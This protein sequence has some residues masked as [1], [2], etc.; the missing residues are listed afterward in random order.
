M[1]GFFFLSYLCLSE[2]PANTGVVPREEHSRVRPLALLQVSTGEGEGDWVQ[3]V[4]WQLGHG[5]APGR[6]VPL[7]LASARTSAGE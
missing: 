4:E 3:K 2:Q 1:A 7:E 6:Q 5:V